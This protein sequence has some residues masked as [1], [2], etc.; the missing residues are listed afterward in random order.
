[1][2]MSTVYMP[3]DKIPMLPPELISAFSLDE[4]QW[5]PALS[6]YVTARLEDGEILDTETRLERI[7]VTANLRHGQ[8]GEVTEAALADPE[9]DLPHGHWLRPLWQLAQALCAVRDRKRGKPENN[10]RIE[11]SFEIDG[12]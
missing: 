7:R 6:L 11:Y 2:R 3:G 10:D 12:P 9:T 4:G 8:I 1:A 5:R